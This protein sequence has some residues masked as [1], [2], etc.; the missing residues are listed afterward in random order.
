MSFV[1]LAKHGIF[2]VAR[3]IGAP[4]LVRRS[5]W[6]RDRLLILCFH[7]VSLEDEHL[8]KPTLFIRQDVLRARLAQLR[9][10]GYSVVSLDEGVR[11]MHDGTLPEGAVALTFDDGTYDFLSRAFPVLKEFG[12]PATV[13]QTTRYAQLGSPVFDVFVAY[14]LWKARDRTVDLSAI[15]PGATAGSLE[16]VP[17]RDR[18]LWAVLGF[19]ER[20]RLDE[21]ARQRLAERLA[22]ALGIDVSPIL[23]RRILSLMNA[24]EIA[25]LARQ[26][27][28]FQ[29]HTHRHQLFEDRAA[30][31]A[32]LRDNRAF[33]EAA[34]GRA[35]THFCYPSGVYRTDAQQW[36]RESGV[37]SATTCDP[38]LA[39]REGSPMLLPRL[40]VTEQL[41]ALVFESWVSGLAALLPRRTQLAHP[42]QKER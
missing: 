27:I 4:A 20:E 36:L 18:I 14:L 12:Y 29:L 21:E 32:D 19:A 31:D 3:R 16:S 11:R 1:R 38:G 7:G 8:W 35:A 41:S 40:V 13:Y 17:H 22:A 37:V 5:R 6:R 28:D 24:A 33:I 10:G 9:D 23:R 39:H 26:G 2:D 30:F 42:E 15:V 25:E 34:T